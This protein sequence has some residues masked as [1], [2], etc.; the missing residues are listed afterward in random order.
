MR[1]SDGKTKVDKKAVQHYNN[2]RSYE[3]AATAPPPPPPILESY[4]V[5]VPLMTV[6]ERVEIH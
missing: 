6:I 2:V 5:F 3:P 1:P 4:E